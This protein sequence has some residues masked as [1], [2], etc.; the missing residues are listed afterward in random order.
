[1]SDEERDYLAEA[2][3]S[4]ELAMAMAQIS[5][6]TASATASLRSLDKISLPEKE[7][8]SSRFDSPDSPKDNDDDK[9]FEYPDMSKYYSGQ[10]YAASLPGVS[11]YS[12]GFSLFGSGKESPR[13]S[14]S[15]SSHSKPSRSTSRDS[16]TGTSSATS[17]GGGVMKK[18]YIGLVV[19]FIAL[20]L[21]DVSQQQI[22]KL[23][24]SSSQ[25]VMISSTRDRNSS[26]FRT[27]AKLPKT[28]SKDEPLQRLM[29]FGRHG[30]SPGKFDQP[31]GIAMIRK[32]F[33]F[34]SDF[35]NK[36]V[37]MLLFHGAPDVDEQTGELVIDKVFEY[38]LEMDQI[39]GP[40]AMTT[41]GD[42]VI[43][44][45]WG[46]HRLK[47]IKLEAKSGKLVPVGFFGE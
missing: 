26:T 2:R 46:M 34:I 16:G 45:E 36:R 15:S 21:I 44:A 9:D 31:K 38:A 18:V 42:Y 17:K 24:S 12:S 30:A 3:Q 1:M 28:N 13:D 7:G 4:R 19:A 41:I 22:P 33:L 47:I 39:G 32:R 23:N 11:S 14:S 27:P 5:S 37:Q 35:G 25:G 8:S 29:V 6:L 20:L 43:I 40:L 10:D